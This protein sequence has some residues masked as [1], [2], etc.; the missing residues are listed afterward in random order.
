M[1]PTSHPRLLLAAAALLPLAAGALYAADAVRSTLKL[2]LHTDG[3]ADAVEIVDLDELEVGERRDY[4]TDSGK[5]LAVTRDDDGYAIEIEGKTIRVADDPHALAAHPGMKMR[6]IVLDGDGDAD[7]L[8]ISDDVRGAEPGTKM[9][10]RRIEIDGDGDAK[11]FVIADGPEAHRV[12]VRRGPGGAQAFAFG[13]GEPLLRF[14]PHGLLER[15][16]KSDRFLALDDATQELVRELV[17]EAAGPMHWVEGGEAG[18]RVE[19]WLERRGES[20]EDEPE[21]K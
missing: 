10:M 7:S 6:R 8:V 1:R 5:P 16:E 19:V 12:V 14:G 13:D 11:S 17:R 15:I 4:T 20:D 21:R 9:K 18:D 2:K 3:A